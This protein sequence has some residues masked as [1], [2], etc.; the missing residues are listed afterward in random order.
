MA[1]PIHEEATRLN[2][3]VALTINNKVEFPPTH[4]WVNFT[5]NIR[6]GNTTTYGNYI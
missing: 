3:L 2:F 1:R 6:I 4:R 5:A